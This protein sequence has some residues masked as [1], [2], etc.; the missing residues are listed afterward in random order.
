MARIRLLDTHEMEPDIRDMCTA[1]ETQT[2][3]STAMRIVAHR[4]DILR[5]FA[6]FYWQL[7]TEGLL[8]RKLIELVRLSI[9]QINECQNCLAGRY[10]DS[11]DEGLTEE[12]IAALPMA[13]SSPLFTD[14]EKAA[15]SYGQKMAADHFS[16]GDEDFIRLHQFFTE[17]EL[18]ELCMDV[19]QFIGIGRMFAV[20]DARNT[21]CAIPASAK[22]AEDVRIRTH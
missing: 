3:D 21:V 11:F 12:L 1:I 6:K 9:A 15:I 17:Q 4:P 16:V 8:S 22:A 19:A 10:Q 13:E 18:V 20:L 7:Q 2:G 14:R 5:S